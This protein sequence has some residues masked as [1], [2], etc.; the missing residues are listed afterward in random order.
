MRRTVR[1]TERDLTRLVRR[2]IREQ[3]IVE[4]IGVIP[5]SKVN[6]RSRIGPKGTYY[7]DRNGGL[8]INDGDGDTLVLSDAEY[9][10][11]KEN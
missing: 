9:D 7:V 11:N 2:V 3:E 6:D 4:A 10:K 1:L 5:L 8:V